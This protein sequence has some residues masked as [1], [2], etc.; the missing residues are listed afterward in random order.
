MLVECVL[1]EHP[2]AR[3]Q[4]VM[5]ADPDHLVGDVFAIG[6]EEDD[7]EDLAIEPTEPGRQQR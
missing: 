4:Q 2:I 3:M 1:D 6:V 7:Q 5:T